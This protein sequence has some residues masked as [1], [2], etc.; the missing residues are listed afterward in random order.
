LRKWLFALPAGNYALSNRSSSDSSSCGGPICD[1]PKAGRPWSRAAGGGQQLTG[2]NRT[3]ARQRVGRWP[4]TAVIVTATRCW[5][6][7]RRAWS[8]GFGLVSV[9]RKR[10]PAW[11]G[12]R[13]PGHGAIRR[14]RP[15]RPGPPGP[16]PFALKQRAGRR[17][18]SLHRHAAIGR[19]VSAARHGETGVPP[20]RKPTPVGGPG[21]N[22]AGRRLTAPCQHTRARARM[23]MLAPLLA[24]RCSAQNQ[25]V[26]P[27]PAQAIPS[28]EA[29]SERRCGLVPLRAASM[30]VMASADR[31]LCGRAASRPRQM[32]HA[33]EPRSRVTCRGTSVGR[34]ASLRGRDAG[35]RQNAQSDQQRAQRAACLPCAAHT[36]PGNGWGR[37]QVRRRGRCASRAAQHSSALCRPRPN[38]LPPCAPGR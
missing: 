13:L 16:R 1:G 30:A 10:L 36:R 15:P 24:P 19:S 11:G 34:K 26:R 25:A 27:A 12:A 31:P 3:R 18:R 22:R 35:G 8:D 2:G 28:T 17:H 7:Q 32:P 21:G 6:A 23:P 9:G 14:N 5:R 4:W 20:F 38:P 29:A 37:H 33:V